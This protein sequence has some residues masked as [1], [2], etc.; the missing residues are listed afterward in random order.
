MLAS[1]G[2]RANAGG[3]V[4]L[5]WEG[6]DGAGDALASPGGRANAWA[7]RTEAG[8]VLASPGGR[9]NAGEGV[10]LAWEGTVPSLGGIYLRRSDSFPGRVCLGR[11]DYFPRGVDLGI[12]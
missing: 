1:P 8:D 4:V 7:G 5:A 6:R 11:S 10:E 12:I 9:A 2:G 3:R